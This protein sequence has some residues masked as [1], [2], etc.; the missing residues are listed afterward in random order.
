MD[1]ILKSYCLAWPK[2]ITLFND[3]NMIWVALIVHVW[4]YLRFHGESCSF[5]VLLVGK[6]VASVREVFIVGSWRNRL[7]KLEVLSEKVHGFS[8]VSPPIHS[9]QLWSECWCLRHM[10][11]WVMTLDFS[12]RTWLYALINKLWIIASHNIVYHAK[13]QVRLIWK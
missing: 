9:H 8:Y 4:E 11:L 10:C 1:W 7:D 12:V 13:T 5:R 2:F 6:G 3:R